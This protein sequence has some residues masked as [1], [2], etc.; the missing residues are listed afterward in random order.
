M[1]LCTGV[2]PRQNDMA[3]KIWDLLT[4]RNQASFDGAKT[5]QVMQDACQWAMER[6]AEHLSE[7][8]YQFAGQSVRIRIVGQ[9]LATHLV[10]PFSHL[11]MH[12]PSPCIPQLTID[13]WDENETGIC[14]RTNSQENVSRW[15]EVG[16][17]SVEGRFVGHQLPNSVTCLD[18]HAQHII[19][20][21]AWGETVFLYERGKPLTMPLTAWYS[22]RN[23]PVIH[24]SL[25]SRDGQGVLFAG[26]SGSGKSTSSLA[27]LQDG[28][29]YLSED[30]VGLQKL[31]DG[32]FVGYSLYNSAFVETSHLAR[33]P[34]L[35]PYVR[36]AQFPSE[37]KSL[38]LLSQVFPE[39]LKGSVPIR[40]LVLP[41]VTDLPESQIRPAA[42]GQ[43][44]LTLG[45][46]TLLS[47]PGLGTRRL[48]TLAR[49]V[50]QVPCYWLD[51]G[52]EL[53]SIPHCMEELLAEITHHRT[54]SGSPYPS[55][56]QEE[57]L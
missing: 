3:E 4:L 35:T 9:K 31:P 30:F 39:R 11:R 23:V 14:C 45:P 52:R 40:L 36:K 6:Y 21:L 41:R 28:F 24:A 43:A 22:D 16:A 37:K 2:S 50:E 19:G 18:R 10:L 49:L 38:V 42:K 56:P 55:C 51:L 53:K 54:A 26:W 32:S 46:S 34:T 47:V 27:C 1:T 12:G 8:F 33:F 57:K 44:L 15:T 7:S 48:D 20:S 25:V 5:F 17:M 13:L 29:D